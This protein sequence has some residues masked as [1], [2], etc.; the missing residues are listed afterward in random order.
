VSVELYY[1]YATL[2]GRQHYALYGILCI[3]YAI[4]VSVTACVSIALTYFQLSAEDYHWWWRSVFS[5]GSTAGFV[6]IYSVF[7]YFW[8]S[9]MTGVMQSVEYFGYSLLTCYIFFLSLGTISF[10]ASLK[11]VRYIYVNVKMD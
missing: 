6:L 3:I 10:F 5:A 8:R 9:N 1:I 7:Y 4:L 2:W 11:F